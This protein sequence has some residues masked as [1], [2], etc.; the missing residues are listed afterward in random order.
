MNK[1]DYV[2]S[3]GQTR[4]HGCHWPGCD[5]QVP[6]ARWGCKTHWFRLPKELRDKIW[7]AYQPGQE[8]TGKP[9]E[10]YLDAA[11]EVQAWIAEHGSPNQTKLPL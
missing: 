7:K 5:R 1:A 4:P 8:I 9:S 2:L 10:A 6:P 3:Q 11:R